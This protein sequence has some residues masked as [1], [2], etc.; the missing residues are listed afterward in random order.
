[1]ET[2]RQY[3]NAKTSAEIGVWLEEEHIDFQPTPEPKKKPDWSKFPNFKP[4]EFVCPC[5]KCP[6][7]KPEYVEE[8]LDEGLLFIL[9][10]NR[11]KFGIVNISS[12][13][14]CKAYNDSLKGSVP[15]SPHITGKAADFGIPGK[16]N[17]V[18]GRNEVCEYDK[19]LP[20]YKYS[21]HNSNGKY[22]N[23]GSCIHV[24]T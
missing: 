14:R 22:P 16:T 19:K 8:N 7:S 12:G 2:N 13:F 3:L 5:G 1:M 20:C 24:N 17:T 18:S 15:N 4:K 10:A 6:Q 21:Y 9:Q 23:M 11:N